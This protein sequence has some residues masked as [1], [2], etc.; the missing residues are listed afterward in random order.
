ML[1]SI[2]KFLYNCLFSKRRLGK[3]QSKVWAF[4]NLTRWGIFLGDAA[5]RNLTWLLEFNPFNIL[6]RILAAWQTNS[7]QILSLSFSLFL[8]F[9]FSLSLSLFLSLSFSQS[10]YLSFSLSLFLSLF[11]SEFEDNNLVACKFSHC[12]VTYFESKNQFPFHFTPLKMKL[13]P[14]F[15][16]T[17]A[18]LFDIRK[19]LNYLF[20]Q[21]I[22]CCRKSLIRLK[23][24]GWQR[25]QSRSKNL[26]FFFSYI[27]EKWKYALIYDM[28]SEIIEISH[29]I[30]HE[31]KLYYDCFN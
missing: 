7:C 26:I 19:I 5:I 20:C 21:W 16:S 10:L 1:S 24:I 6:N 15:S 8:F 14:K 17:K 11:L 12:S 13:V 30:L 25:G 28:R 31:T 29:S 22:H 2:R 9:S 4:L 18:D 27:C 23:R 3:H